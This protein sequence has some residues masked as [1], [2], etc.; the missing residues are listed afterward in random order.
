V[1]VDFLADTRGVTP[2]RRKRTIPLLALAF[3]GLFIAERAMPGGVP[4]GVGFTVA[5]F[6]LFGF[7]RSLQI[8]AVNGLKRFRITPRTLLWF[9]SVVAF[10]Y[11]TILWI[12][13]SRRTPNF[14]LFLLNSELKT[15]LYYVWVPAF[16][17]LGLSLE[18]R[19]ESG[20]T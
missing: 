20:K 3:A 4:D 16:V 9:A 11:S 2:E 7:G 5:A 18:A 14:P 8:Y 17:A 19:S 15:T 6:S 13:W 12:W 1:S 10:W